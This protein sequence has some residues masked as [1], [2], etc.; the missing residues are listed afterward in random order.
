MPTPRQ[1]RLRSDKYAA[2]I[3]KRGKVSQQNAEVR[4]TKTRYRSF[5]IY[6]RN[7]KVIKAMSHRF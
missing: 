5:L 3:T 4:T 2:N 7:E 6:F 1:T